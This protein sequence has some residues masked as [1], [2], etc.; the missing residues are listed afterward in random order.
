MR[1]TIVTSAAILLI[2]FLGFKWWESSRAAAL[3]EDLLSVEMAKSAGFETQIDEMGR[4]TAIQEQTIVNQRAMNTILRAENEELKKVKARVIVKQVT[5]LDTILMTLTDTVMVLGAD[6]PRTVRS[7]RYGDEWTDIRGLVLDSAVQITRL[8]IRDSLSV[9]IG[10]KRNGFLRRRSK[11]I[12]VK[13]HNPHTA[14]QGLSNIIVQRN[15]KK[16]WTFLGGVAVGVTAGVLRR[17]H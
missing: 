3:A 17:T 2:I 11:V 14:V 16:I 4:E 1:N 6:T 15:R 10:E 12:Q 5:S 7:F 8:D 13:N 9:T